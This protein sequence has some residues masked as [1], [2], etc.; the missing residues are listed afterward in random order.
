MG[1]G[2]AQRVMAGSRAARIHVVS[3]AT[4]EGFPEGDDRGLADGSP[5][6]SRDSAEQRRGS[7]HRPEPALRRTCWRDGEGGVA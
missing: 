2:R 1:L 7:S 6:T 4:C 5:R 3:G